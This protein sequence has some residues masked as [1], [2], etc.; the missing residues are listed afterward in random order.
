MSRRYA[1]ANLSP[2]KGWIGEPL[3]PQPILNVAMNP[4]GAIVPLGKYVAGRAGAL[5]YFRAD[6]EIKRGCSKQP[7]LSFCLVADAKLLVIAPLSVT[8]S[9]VI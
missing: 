4:Y 8:P 9:G 2:S 6:Q 3:P 1:L 5:E 7:S